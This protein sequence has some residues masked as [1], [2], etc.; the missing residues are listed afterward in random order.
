M[1]VCYMKWI[2]RESVGGGGVNGVWVGVIMES[3]VE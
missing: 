2:M 3:G 1:C